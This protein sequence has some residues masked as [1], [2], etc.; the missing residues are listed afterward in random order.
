M[1][2]AMEIEGYEVHANQKRALTGTKISS[3][4]LIGMRG[5]RNAHHESWRS[6]EHRSQANLR[7]HMALQLHVQP[8][9]MTVHTVEQE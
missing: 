9:V 2:D 8:R 4:N 1:G 6:V 5:G 3:S 7:R